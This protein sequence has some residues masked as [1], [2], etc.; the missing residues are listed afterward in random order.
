MFE[1]NLG[2]WVL[3][4]VILPAPVWVP[5]MFAAY[6]VGQRRFSLWLLF[7]LIAAEAATL[8]IAIASLASFVPPQH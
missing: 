1:S 2:N 5:I 3:V 6:A 7:A 8:G 4:L